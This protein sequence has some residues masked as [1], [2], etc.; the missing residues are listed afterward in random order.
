M[1][2]FL[3]Y[4]SVT[5]ELQLSEKRFNLYTS[6]EIQKITIKAGKIDMVLF[7]PAKET[8]NPKKTIKKRK[9]K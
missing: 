7:L 4:S 5:K 3:S 6:F 1:Q 9:K 8:E 2:I